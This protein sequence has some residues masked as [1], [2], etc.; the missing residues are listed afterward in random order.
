[1][2]SVI[3][4]SKTK[5]NVQSLKVHLTE[6]WHRASLGPWYSELLKKKKKNCTG[7]LSPTY[8]Y[9][10]DFAQ[11]PVYNRLFKKLQTDRLLN[12]SPITFLFN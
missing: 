12:L 7:V 10:S 11:M 2:T 3:K 9:E 4:I 8:C 5:T 6:F 1:M